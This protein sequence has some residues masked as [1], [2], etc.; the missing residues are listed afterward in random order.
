MRNSQSYSFS[1]SLHYS[2]TPR[3]QAQQRNRLH[4][5]LNLRSPSWAHGLT[6][7]LSADGI[8]GS[9]MFPGVLTNPQVEYIEQVRAA[10]TTEDGASLGEGSCDLVIS[11]PALFTC[12]FH[13]FLTAM[14]STFC[15]CTPH[16]YVLPHH[17]LGGNGAK[18]YALESL[19]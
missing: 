1:N 14:V 11:C 18:D 17:R 3:K 9:D 6:S 15:Q 4:I 16:H 5:R 19:K 10:K 7:W 2:G 8:S 12:F 13:C